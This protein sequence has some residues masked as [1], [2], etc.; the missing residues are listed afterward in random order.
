MM[1]WFYKTLIVFNTIMLLIL[2][3]GVATSWQLRYLAAKETETYQ[4]VENLAVNGQFYNIKTFDD[5]DVILVPVAMTA[6][7]KAQIAFKEKY[8]R[9][10]KIQS[11]YRTATAQDWLFKMYQ[12][13]KNPYIVETP[14][15]SYHQV[16]L[17]VDV[18]EAD[19]DLARPFLLA[20]G[21]S[22]L[23]EQDPVHFEYRWNSK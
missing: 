19:M 10:F 7:T 16:G 18:M 11:S 9:Y 21:F 5:Q 13:G 17:A 12:Y 8:N 1:H 15:Y 22:D 3:F 4:L 20:E 2:C 6:F 14:G 23:G